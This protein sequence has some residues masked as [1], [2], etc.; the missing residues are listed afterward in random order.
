MTR[1]KFFVYAGCATVVLKSGSGRCCASM[2]GTSNRRLKN[3]VTMRMLI[4]IFSQTH[5]TLLGTVGASL[6]GRPRYG[7]EGHPATFPDTWNTARAEGRPRS[8]APT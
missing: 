1:G 2:S 4:F 6:R 3:T 5:P 7:S 8:D